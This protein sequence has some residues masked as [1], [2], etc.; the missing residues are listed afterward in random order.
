MISTLGATRK[1]GQKKHSDGLRKLSD[2]EPLT[3]LEQGAAMNKVS[4]LGVGRMAKR[5]EKRQAGQL[6][7][8]WSN[9]R[10]GQ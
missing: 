9:L 5:C 6:S 7:G 10:L 3:L 1:S 4:T 2:T 8:C